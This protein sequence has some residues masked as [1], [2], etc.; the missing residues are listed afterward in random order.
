MGRRWRDAGTT[1][2]LV[3]FV[4]STIVWFDAAY[5]P[6]PLSLF[7]SSLQR[8]ITPPLASCIIAEFSKFVRF[9][10]NF[11]GRPNF[12]LALTCDLKKA[13]ERGLARNMK[14]YLIVL[15]SPVV[16]GAP[17]WSASSQREVF[18]AVRLGRNEP[19]QR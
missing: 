4:K 18:L 13:K 3:G 14:K 17:L 8:N 5:F 16:G 12:V 11:P 19:G 1:A 7:S 15:P 6:L 2:Q 9:I 10:S